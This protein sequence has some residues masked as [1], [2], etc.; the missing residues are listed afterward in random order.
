MEALWWC[1]GIVM[2]VLILRLRFYRDPDEH[3]RYCLSEVDTR[4]D[5]Y[6]LYSHAIDVEGIRVHGEWLF[7][8]QLCQDL[9]LRETIRGGQ[10]V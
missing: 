3:C 6:Y 8:S 9:H 5:D 10:D 7:C 1:F 4:L 2:I